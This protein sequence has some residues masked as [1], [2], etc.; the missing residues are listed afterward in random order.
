MSSEIIEVEGRSAGCVGVGIPIGPPS[1]VYIR[2]SQEP[3]EHDADSFRTGGCSMPGGRNVSKDPRDSHDHRCSWAGNHMSSV[4]SLVN[5]ISSARGPKQQR[6]SKDYSSL[7]CT[8]RMAV[9]AHDMQSEATAP[10]HQNSSLN[11]RP[12]CAQELQRSASSL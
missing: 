9:S 2:L 5:R 1:S 10:V 8:Y 11:A 6:R 4:S 12:R 3:H 7:Q